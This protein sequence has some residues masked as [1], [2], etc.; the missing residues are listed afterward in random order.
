MKVIVFLKYV[1]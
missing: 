1:K